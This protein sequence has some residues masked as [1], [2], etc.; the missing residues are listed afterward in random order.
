[1]LGQWSYLRIWATVFGPSH[2]PT[3][4]FWDSPIWAIWCM[5]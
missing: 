3:A 5:E 4:L 2:S 1:M